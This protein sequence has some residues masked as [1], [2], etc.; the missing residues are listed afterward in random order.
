[1]TDQLDRLKQALADR[2]AIERELGAGGMATVYLA[3]DLKHD[4]HVALKV[5][6]PELAAVLGAER[7]V[8]EIKTTAQLQHPHILPLFD[9]GEA[10]GF[11]YY[12]M[13]YIEGETL[14]DQLD[15]EKQLGIDEAVQ[16]T[17]EVADALDYA[18]RHNVIHRDIKPENILIHD[19]RPMVADFGIALAVSAA[20]GGRM[21]ETGLSLGT[22]HYMSPEQATADKDL[23]NRSDVYSLGAVLFEMLTGDPPHTGSTAQQIIMK[24]VTDDVR[25]VTELR[26]S[27]PPNVAFAVARS[28]EKLPADRFHNAAEF[29]KAL[30]D[31]SFATSMPGATAQVRGATSSWWRLVLVGSVIGVVLL[32]AGYVL[33]QRSTTG[34]GVFDVGL[35]DTAPVA[36]IEPTPWG[37]EGPALAVSPNGEFV[38]YAARVGEGTELWY[39]SLTTTDARPLP[40]TVEGY[41]PFVSPD[42]QWVAFFAG[43]LLKKVP[44]D[45][46]SPAEDVAEVIE[47]EG[48]VWKTPDE[49]LIG[50]RLGSQLERVNMRTG[51]TT[52]L[53]LRSTCSM[54]FLLEGVDAALCGRTLSIVRLDG[55]ERADIP[56]ARVTVRGDSDDPVVGGH[57]SVVDDHVV[58]VTLRG[59][60]VAATLDMTHATIGVP[61]IVQRGLR[62]SRIW[63]TAHYGIT[64][65]GDLVFVPGSNAAVG[66]FV[67][68]R[69]D[70][71]TEVL[72]IPAR[73]FL[74][75]SV[76]PDGGRIATTARGVGG[77]ELWVFDINGSTGERLVDGYFFVGQPEW[78]RDGRLISHLQGTAAS[79]AVSVLVS[80]RLGELDTLP[81][82]AF[83]TTHVVDESVVVG[84][85]AGH[86]ERD[87]VVVRLHDGSAD[88]LALPED[89]FY[90]SV[91]PDERWLAYTGSQR[92]I[93]QVFVA[94]F[95][96]L[97][98]QFKV[99]PG[100]ASEALWLPDGALVYRHGWCWYRADA[101]PGTVPPLGE[102]RRYFCDEGLLNT[103][104]RSHTTMPDGSILY[105]RSVAPPTGGYLRVVRGWTKHM[106][107]QV[108]SAGA[109]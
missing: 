71:F 60:L 34:P 75:F 17:V 41:Y 10:E 29:A 100:A 40:G 59:D 74:T 68:A 50:S 8:Q 64:R 12:V 28:L 3:H 101:R 22:P 44:V 92:G 88:T 42:G 67:I 53:D 38:V 95:P 48:G 103:S 81:G 99:S 25:L 58:F 69:P 47:P 52:S 85:L 20:A 46:S 62:R 51:S 97:E 27:V 2:Y 39:R 15:R 49:V 109:Q 16:I 55:P 32:A 65:R 66:R 19:G 108:R 76:S 86:Q 89:Q 6:K 56:S 54:P 30:Q 11:L 1:M 26:K 102:P 72:G 79:P 98:R 82:L 91:S 37:S 35:P 87:L 63:P 61:I 33:G 93:A 105:L 31:P 14:R 4:R 106:R 78:T 83:R 57:P 24:I 43:R 23:T 21:T 96:S 90:P 77:S 5:L 13:P 45:G 84:D 107:D 18:H 104:G 7:F 94:P 9:S 70:G 73:E 80:P 36:F